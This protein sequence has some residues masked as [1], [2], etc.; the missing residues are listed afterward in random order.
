M[1][2]GV[3][4]CTQIVQIVQIVHRL[5]TQYMYTTCILHIKHIYTQQYLRHLL[6]KYML[7]KKNVHRCSM[8]IVKYRGSLTTFRLLDVPRI[9][10]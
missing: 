9:L 5:C 1:Y 3:H 6:A 7:A 4:R 10:H 2:T 8:L